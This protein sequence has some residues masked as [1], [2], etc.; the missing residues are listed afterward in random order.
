MNEGI[1]DFRFAICDLSAGAVLVTQT[2]WPSNCNR[3]SAAFRLQK[4]PNL[5]NPWRE[6]TTH[7]IGRFCRPE[8]GAPLSTPISAQNRTI[9][10][11]M[12][13]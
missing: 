3:R 7:Q 12:A 11:T 4:Y 5:S 10:P 9:S 6:P 13:D 1:F 2:W 8:G